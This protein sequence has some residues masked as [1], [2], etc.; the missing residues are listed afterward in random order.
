LLAALVCDLKSI[1]RQLFPSTQVDYYQHTEQVHIY[2][3]I[4]QLLS[5]TSFL[6]SRRI[7]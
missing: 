4:C 1:F 7:R 3:L 5:L 6:D 2:T